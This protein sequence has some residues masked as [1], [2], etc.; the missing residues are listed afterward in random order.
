M[1]W[2]ECTY[3]GNV[4]VRA[5]SFPT[6]ETTKC[7]RSQDSN[8]TEEEPL[9]RRSPVLIDRRAGIRVLGISAGPSWSNGVGQPEANRRSKESPPTEEYRSFRRPPVEKPADTLDTYER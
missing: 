4:P 6:K 1:E 7:R 2:E 9:I 8:S 3:D 5:L